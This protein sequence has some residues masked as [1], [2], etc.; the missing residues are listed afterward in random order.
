[1]PPVLAQGLALVD[2]HRQQRIMPQR[3]VIIEIL[4]AQKFS[5][6]RRTFS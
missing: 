6:L 5:V 4:I 1:M 3:V 2:R